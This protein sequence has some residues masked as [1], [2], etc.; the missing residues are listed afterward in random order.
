MTT[1]IP[2]VKGRLVRASGDAVGG[3]QV[4]LRIGGDPPVS[5]PPVTSDDD[6]GFQIELAETVNGPL[7]LVGSEPLAA[8][9]TVDLPEAAVYDEI[10]VVLPDRAPDPRTQVERVAKVLAA[11]REATSSARV[12]LAEEVGTRE[13]KE[14]RIR[15]AVDAI[16]TDLTS[17]AGGDTRWKATPGRSIGALTA[18]AVRDGRR[19]VSQA[20]PAVAVLPGKFGRAD[21]LRLGTRELLAELTGSP[22]PRDGYWRV[23]PLERLRLRQRH[24]VPDGLPKPQGG[25]EPTDGGQLVEPGKITDEAAEAIGAAASEKVES[26]STRCG[27]QKIRRCW[28]PTAW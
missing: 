6:A 23:D 8:D 13:S 16:L 11:E 1:V 12:V 5:L 19:V 27:F 21:E 25:G 22:Q 2:A 15:Q 14:G 28:S 17:G 10:I 26:L 7:T 20:P 4:V 24:A 9:I 18:D 3:A